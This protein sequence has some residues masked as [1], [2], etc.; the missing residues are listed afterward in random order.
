MELGNVWVDLWG[1][2]YELAPAYIRNPDIRKGIKMV[3]QLDRV[4][5][6][7]KRLENERQNLCNEVARSVLHAACAWKQ[8]LSAY[9][10]SIIGKTLT[11][12]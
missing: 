3:L 5:E 11:L 2:K 9:I 10:L 4:C 12:C 7:R 8:H 6:E 1:E